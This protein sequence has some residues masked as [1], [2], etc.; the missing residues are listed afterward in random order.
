MMPKMRFVGF[1]GEWQAQKLGDIGKTQS[2][3]GFPEKE[4]GGMEG[5]P[6]F[7]VSDMN[8]RGNEK[9]MQSSNNYVSTMQIEGRGWNVINSIPAIIFAKAGAALFL[10]RKRLVYEPFLIDNNLMAYLFDETWDIDFA[11][12]LFDT[13]DLPKYAQIGVLPSFSCSDIKAIEIIRPPH[14]EQIAI[15][16]FFL[17]LDNSIALHQRKLHGLKELKRAY[18]QQIFPQASESVPRLRFAG[19]TEPWQQRKLGETLKDLKNGLSR[20]LSD[21]DIGL[22]VIRANNINQGCLDLRNDIKY[23]YADDPKGAKTKKYHVHSGDILINFINSEAKMGTTAIVEEEPKR[24]TIY[25][26]NILKAQ[27]NNDYDSYFWFA[28]T[29]TEKYKIDIKIITKPAVNQASFTTVD[30]KALEYRMPILPEQIAIG[31]FFRKLGQQINAQAQKLEQLKSLRA[32]Y[33][34]QLFALEK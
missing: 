22:P 5:I 30:F 14:S 10:D 32:V 28:L 12:A 3:V 23:W 27:I 18:L 7:K 13:I 29:Q 34:Q 24:N 8:L 21:A 31:N 6:F 33:L 1:D 16:E 26:T 19:F 4:Q 25:T 11:K 2:G 20:M 17:D 15:G 9:I